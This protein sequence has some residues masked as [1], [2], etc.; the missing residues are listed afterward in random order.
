M[1]IIIYVILAYVLYRIV[2]GV[3]IPGRKIDDGKSNG[4]IDEMIQDPSCKTYIPR[5]DAIRKII[6]GK[7]YFFCSEKCAAQFES[8]KK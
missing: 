8:E 1:R 2:K 4:V 6:A 5:R 3:L 7:E